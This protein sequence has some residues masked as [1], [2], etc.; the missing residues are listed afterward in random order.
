L[1]FSPVAAIAAEVN[2]ANND[3]NENEEVESTHSDEVE[4]STEDG[5]AVIEADEVEGN[6]EDTIEI[7]ELED[8]DPVAEENNNEEATEE[9]AGEED[10]AAETVEADEEEEISTLATADEDL[11]LG[12]IWGTANGDITFDIASGNYILEL[13]AG[14]SNYTNSQDIVNKWVGFAIPNGVRVVGELPSGVVQIFIA[15]KSGL[16]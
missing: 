16:A 12:D 5:S 7:E 4:E 6:E 1:A 11:N 10:N 13:Q 14:L 9:E 2:E 15:G 3:A 8:A